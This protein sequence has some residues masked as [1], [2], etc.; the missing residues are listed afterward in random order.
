M[1]IVRTESLEMSKAIT[2]RDKAAM[3]VFKGLSMSV[4]KRH[5]P[6]QW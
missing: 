3:V 4:G 1:D 6:A 2:E 5:Y